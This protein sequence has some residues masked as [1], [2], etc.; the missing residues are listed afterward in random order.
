[1]KELRFA[2]IGAGFWANFQIAGWLETGGAKCVGICDKARSKAELLAHKFGQ[3]PAYDD[4]ETMLRETKPDFVD[5]ATDVGTHAKF[6][7]LA[8]SLGLPV[9]CQKPLGVTYEEAESML[10]ACRSAGV[11][12][13]V[14]ENWRWQRPIREFKRRMES[15]GI[16][17]VFRARIRM[18][19]GFRV[20]EN[21]PFLR[22]LDQLILTDLGT[23]LLDTARF[24]FG[25]PESLYCQ[26]Y[27]AQKD[28][29]GEDVATVILKMKSGATVTIE[30]AYAGNCLEQ[31]RFP[32]TA[33]FAE[34]TEGSA[35]LQLDHWVR[36]T[37]KDGTWIQ[38]C[39]PPRYDWA[40]PS[41][42]VV[43]S[44]IVPCHAN[45]LAAMRGECAAETAGEDYLKTVRLVFLS[46][47]SA[48]QNQAL[49]V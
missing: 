6:T 27:T 31:D 13:Y 1:M 16:G 42:D 19:S 47:E 33:I 11:Q 26:I 48:S 21:Q 9:V 30:M 20:M 14:N 39:P 45:L 41:Y 17:E 32:E 38:R 24:L 28:I 18:A 2:T 25:E 35:E 4:A 8:A 34:A 43:H 37:S 29:A 23:H 15:G 36:I 10:A 49:R 12:L 7:K 3:P 44:S 22:N 5:I 46:Y 40:D